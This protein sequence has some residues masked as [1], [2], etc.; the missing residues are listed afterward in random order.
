MVLVDTSVW[1]SHL[2]DGNTELANLLNNGSVLC[3]PLIV[4][5]LACGNLKDRAVIISFLKL[6]PI[7]IEAEHEEVLSF[8]ENNRLM[9]KGIGY[10]D[11]Q[12]VASA[13]LT[14]VPIWTLDNK[15][16][17]VADRLHVKYRY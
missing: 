11:A 16:A 3:H 4:G 10:V 8:I 17:Q 5:E 15:L 13:V 6:L 1:V 2:R 7:S 9:G 14:G 12:L